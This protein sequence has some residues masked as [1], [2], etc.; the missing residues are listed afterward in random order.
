M[1]RAKLPIVDLFCGCGGISFG[2]AEAAARMGVD[3]DIRLAVDVDPAAL[4]VFERN[5][6]GRV[7][8][9]P[10]EALFPGEP[11]TPAT[12]A[13]RALVDEIGETVVLCGG[14]PCQGSSN[15]NNWTR[16]D[17]PRNA[18]YSRMARAAELL[19]PAVVVIENVPSV[20]HDR[21]RVVYETAQALRA[22]GYVVREAVIDASALGVP[23]KRKR[24]ILLAAREP[25]WLAVLD[26][27]WRCHVRPVSWAISDL[28]DL[29]PAGSYDEPPRTTVPNIARIEWLFDHDRYE[30]DNELRPVCHHGQHSYRSMYGRLHWDQPAQTITSGFGSMGQGRFVHPLRRRMLTPHEAARLQTFPDHFAFGDHGRT[31]LA[32]MIGNAVPPLLNVVLGERLLPSLID[33][34]RVAW[35]A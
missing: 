35:A 29:K 22:A 28:L 7:S 1:P 6:G 11:G 23:Q 2:L 5:V 8:D 3:L 15:L 14:P 25:A 16:R 17:D 4:E 32:R 10:V 18:L 34:G 9:C 26:D 12:R 21:R 27:L 31:A 30:L 33:E 13:E 20:R 24:H 19:R